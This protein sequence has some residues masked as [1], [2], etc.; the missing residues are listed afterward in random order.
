MNNLDFKQ[1]LMFH[2]F[3][4]SDILSILKFFQS[5]LSRHYEIRT[6]VV[7][8]KLVGS[9]ALR[10]RIRDVPRGIT[11]KH[12]HTHFFALSLSHTRTLSLEWGRKAKSN[13]VIEECAL[14]RDIYAE[15]PSKKTISQMFPLLSK[16]TF[17][18]HWKYKHHDKQNNNS[19]RMFVKANVAINNASFSD[20][21]VLYSRF[22]KYKKIYWNFRKI[23]GP[24]NF[25]FSGW[26]WKEEVRSIR[27]GLKIQVSD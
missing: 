5:R 10:R 22:D 2:F 26:N 12:T 8:I 14:T 9:E 18:K 1:Y 15:H 27:H 24:F 19:N 20:Y 25:T 6:N 13:Y 4:S 17:K 11:F 23:N 3:F 16:P 7:A 21:V